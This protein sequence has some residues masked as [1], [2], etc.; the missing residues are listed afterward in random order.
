MILNDISPDTLRNYIDL[1]S[2]HAWSDDNSRYIG[3][4][5][6]ASEIDDEHG[7]GVKIESGKT[8]QVSDCDIYRNGF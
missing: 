5:F 8:S 1:I 3:L 4:S 2:V 7:I 6:H